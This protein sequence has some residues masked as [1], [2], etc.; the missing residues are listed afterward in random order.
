[1]RALAIVIMLLL[2][3]GAGVFF[4]LHETDQVEDA[5][6]NVADFVS[7]SADRMRVPVQKALGHKPHPSKIIYLNREGAILSQGSDDAR[8]NVSSILRLRDRKS[9]V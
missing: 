1:M 7:D 4:Y 6:D 9:V 5:V 2:G 8:K 3:A